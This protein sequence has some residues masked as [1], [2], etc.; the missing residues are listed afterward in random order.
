MI[1]E[2]VFRYQVCDFEL[3]NTLIEL[4]FEDDDLPRWDGEEYNGL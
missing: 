4:T 1:V 3:F 2:I